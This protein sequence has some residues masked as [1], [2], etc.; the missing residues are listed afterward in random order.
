MKRLGLLFVIGLTVL[1]LASTAAAA[2]VYFTGADAGRHVRPRT[3]A[4][5]GDGTLEVSKVHWSAWGGMF[6]RGS[7]EAE[8]HGCTPKC[9]SA[10]VH[11]AHVS[12]RLSNIRSCGVRAYYTHV[13]LTL[14]SGRLL[15]P[16]FLR[17]SYKPR[18]C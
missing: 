7:G 9:A 15:E 6:A 11:H 17:I 4:L 12:I 3:L 18:P 14:P 2:T 16:R 5:T 8:Y 1:A 13:R 10:P